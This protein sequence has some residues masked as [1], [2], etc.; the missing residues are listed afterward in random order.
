MKQKT[1]YEGYDTL[2]QLSDW[3]FSAAALGLWEY[4]NFS[5][6]KYGKLDYKILSAIEKSEEL[7]KEAIK[8]LDGILYHSSDITE[9]RYLD[10]AEYWFRS[11]MTHCKIMD[12]LDGD[13]LSDDDIK[14]VNDMVK[15]KKVLQNLLGKVKFNGENSEEYISIIQKN[16]HHIIKEIYRYSSMMYRGFNGFNDPKKIKGINPLFT[17]ENPH[18]RLQGYYI[19]ENRKSNSVGYAFDK[20]TFV[21]SDCIEFDFI[22]FAF[23]N[24]REGYFIN[25]NF[26]LNTL[27]QT[28]HKFMQE[29]NGTEEK[30]SRTKLYLALK[31]SAD[32]IRYD[33][34]II[35]KPRDIEQ[36][37]TLFVRADRLKA[38]QE[39]QS[40]NLKFNYKITDDYYFNL[41]NEVYDKCLNN[42]MLDSCIEFMLKLGTENTQQ[43]KAARIQNAKIIDINEKWKGEL[44]MSDNE[45]LN[46]KSARATGYSV[47]EWFMDNDG[48]NKLKSYKQKLISSIV[49]HDYDRMNEILLNLS[50]YTGKEL[51][52]AYQLFENPENNIGLAYA[53]A[54]ALT[55]DVKNFNKKENE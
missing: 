37:Q 51:T 49:A 46:I 54:N 19:D 29:I 10:F 18:C 48:E 17:K 33:V 15:S 7:P 36:Y 4:L 5:V 14:K 20:D 25:N 32:Y 31:N 38:L 39:L 28:N 24:T 43:G 42:E 9:E 11:E 27:K 12:I 52:F 1:D 8:G 41:E 22:P 55:P 16:R 35:I 47:S 2:L 13:S 26:D 23:S 6:G 3:R 40:D 45:K 53:F 50:S 21:G 30:N 34:E 44:R